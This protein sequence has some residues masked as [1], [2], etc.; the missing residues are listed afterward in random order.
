MNQIN[1]KLRDIKEL[2]KDQVLQKT[3]KNMD[4]VEEIEGEIGYIQK[5]IDELKA[6]I[7]AS[8]PQTYKDFKALMKE[9]EN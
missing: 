8:W 9:E 4:L 2:R 6:T 3:L 1:V 5:E 7:P